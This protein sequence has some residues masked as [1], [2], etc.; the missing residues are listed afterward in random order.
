MSVIEKQQ[1]EE[2]GLKEGSYV[3]ISVRDIGIGM[4]REVMERVF[5]PFFTTK[6]KGRGTGLG[7]ASAYGIIKNHGGE[8]VV[9]SKKGAGT[10]F[11][12]YLPLSDKTVQKEEVKPEKIIAGFETVLVVDDEEAITEISTELIEC[13]GYKAMSAGSGI[14]AL[15]IYKKKMKDI[16]IL[17]IDLIMPEMGGGE[18][19]DRLKKLNP[20]VKVLLSSGYSVDGEASKILE[21]GCCG[22]IQKPFGLHEISQKIREILD[23]TTPG[24]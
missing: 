6:T 4:D 18:L 8:I 21:R 5:E 22:F 1:V 16:D 19:Y 23:G 15:E 3:K 20:D 7:L 11:D 12:V 24:S 9:N 17:I 10:I 2:S 14:E 13:L